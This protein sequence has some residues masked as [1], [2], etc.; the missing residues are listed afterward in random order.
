M[1]NIS[2]IPLQ[3]KIDEFSERKLARAS[4]KGNSE[5]YAELMK[6][7]KNYLYKIAYSYIND[8][9]K[10]LDILQE[11]AYKGL[12]NIKKL[13][14]E[15]YFKTWITRILINI[16]IDYSRSESNLVYLEDETVFIENEKNLSIESKLDL[17]DAINRLRDNY[18]MVIILKYF[19]D[20][21]EEQVSNIMDI[22]INT[23]KSNLRRARLQLKDILKEDEIY[24]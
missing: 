11:T 8:E 7:H 2:K 23:V 6:F 15:K 5:A 13:R 14:E 19:N 21:T 3:R 9:Q 4:I 22:P 12:L 1:L 20:M 24:E 18:K 17:Y 10:A 16:A